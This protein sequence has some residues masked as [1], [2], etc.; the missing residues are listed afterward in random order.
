MNNP[1]YYNNLI[2]AIYH[3]GEFNK[4]VLLKSRIDCTLYIEIIDLNNECVSTCNIADVFVVDNYYKEIS[5]DD[6][7]IIAR[8]VERNVAYNAYKGIISSH[9]RDFIMIHSIYAFDVELGSGQILF[10]AKAIEYK[11]DDSGLIS[12][13]K[14]EKYRFILELN[15]KILFLKK[16]TDWEEWGSVYETNFLKFLDSKTIITGGSRTGYEDRLM[17]W[18]LPTDKLDEIDLL[19]WNDELDDDDIWY[20][21][22]GS[23][24]IYK[25]DKFIALEFE[26]PSYGQDCIK[27]LKI[28]PENELTTIFNYVFQDYRL[29]FIAF[30]PA[31]EEFAILEYTNSN[32]YVLPNVNIRTYGID[33]THI[34]KVII[35]TKLNYHANFIREINYY[36]P[37]I[38]SI[39]TSDKVFLYDLIG[40]NEIAILKKDAKRPYYISAGKIFFFVN[41]KPTTFTIEDGELPMYTANEDYQINYDKPT[42][43]QKKASQQPLTARYNPKPKISESYKFKAYGRIILFI[44]LT[45]LALSKC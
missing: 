20:E 15:G 9:S 11:V 16:S 25:R 24:A 4:L 19:S 38:L 34:P 42:S 36:S 14:S 27:I 32:E 41:E 8:H 12:Q 13:G 6:D 45:V 33:E 21:Y 3:D 22:I 37:Q 5:F 23:F 1:G 28:G 17:L 10:G 31:C 29:L 30:G 7:D 39:I 18:D 35:S 26:N 40:G 44:V 43:D 2:L